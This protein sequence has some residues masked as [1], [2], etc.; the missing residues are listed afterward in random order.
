MCIKKQKLIRKGA[1]GGMAIR[2][3]PCIAVSSLDD[4]GRLT[5]WQWDTDTRKRWAVEMVVTVTAISAGSE[6]IG[7]SKDD[8]RGWCDV[9]KSEKPAFRLGNAVEVTLG[10]GDVSE[11][12][13]T[14]WNGMVG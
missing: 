12:G 8:R 1:Q 10:G 4:D 11:R 7:K 2:H 13:A 5:V 9:S 14:E 3:C 6:K